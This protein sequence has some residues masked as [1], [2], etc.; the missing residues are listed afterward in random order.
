MRR[1]CKLALPLPE[2]LAEDGVLP[3]TNPGLIGV[4]VEAVWLRVLCGFILFG[5]NPRKAA[6]FLS[7]TGGD[8]LAVVPAALVVTGTQ[9]FTRQPA[10]YTIEIK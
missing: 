6:V 9:R 3:D 4:T 2:M 7:F 10:G 5:F 8:S 1:P